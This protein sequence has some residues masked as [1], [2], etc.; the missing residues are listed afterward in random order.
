MKWNIGGNGMTAE[1]GRAAIW[2]YDIAARRARIYASGLRNPNGL[3]LEP[4]TG[5]IWTVVNERDEIGPDLPPDYLTSV[6]D[7]GFYGGPH[8]YWGPNVDQRITQPA[9][10]W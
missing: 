10:T 6:A 9:P 7:G 2:V 5:A 3:D 8:S 1:E 4:N